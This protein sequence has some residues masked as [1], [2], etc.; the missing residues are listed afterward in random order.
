M[1]THEEYMRMAMEEV[2]DSAKE[3]GAPFAVVVVGPRG[4][5]VW[6][7]H[8]RVQA[9][10]DPTAHGEV[11]AIRGLC[12]QLGTLSLEGHAVYTTCQPCPMCFAVCVKTRVS[13]LYF[14]PFLEKTASLPIPIDEMAKYAK[15]YPI[16]VQGGI[17]AQECLAQRLRL[18]AD[19]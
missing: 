18:G 4:D 8:D 14:G 10:G 11:N 2:E 13:A 5:V 1:K 7:D 3:G 19:Q 17:L 9:T 16:K 12:K 15:K 6:R